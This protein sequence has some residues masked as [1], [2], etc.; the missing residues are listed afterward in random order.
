MF[1]PSVSRLPQVLNSIIV[2]LEMALIGT[3]IGV[4]IG[5]IFAV[6][7]SRNLTPN[8]ILYFV[9]RGTITFFRTTPSLVWAIF[10][11]AAV[12]LG[13]RSG[14]VTLVIAT[15]GFCGRFFAE[16]IEE[17]SQE[18]IESLQALGSTKLGVI[19]SVIIP[20]ALPSFVNTIL[21][22]LEH[23]TRSSTVLGIVGAGG[24]GIELMVSIQTFR[25]DEAFT[26][27]FLLFLTVMFV[28]SA[29]SSIRRKFI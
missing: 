22:N 9:S 16:A 17:V 2:T 3:I 5:F 18:H 11:I 24:I 29:C 14:T 15:V 21:F 1:P 19:F 4:P 25:Y 26:I 27:L 13:P 28:E 6:F 8:H 10:L 7:S 12:G 20:E 23:N